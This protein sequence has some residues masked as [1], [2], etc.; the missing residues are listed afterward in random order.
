[1]TDVQGKWALITGASRG[2][3]YHTALFMAGQGA[4]LVL[5]ASKPGNADKVLAEVLAVGV[6]AYTVAADL[7]SQDEISAML[8]EIDSRGTNVQIVLNN[9]GFQVGYRTDYLNTPLSD[10]AASFAVNTIAPAQICY[11]Y[12]P[13]MIEAGFGRIVNT[14]SGIDKD[15]QQAGYS[16]SK[17]ALDK[18]TRD[19]GT[20]VQG[21]DV[22][23]NLADPGWCR[24]DLGGPN[25]F[26]PPESVIPG[27]VTG[28]FANDGKSGRWLGAQD[29]SGMTL[30][31]AVAKAEAIPSPY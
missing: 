31:D 17:A 21:T 30:A 6:Q 7:A 15:P 25:A 22:L 12:L 3:G 11:H 9:A 10:F 8:A 23:I 2:V 20:K 28:V 5:H 4:N 16:A 1:M 19:L 26:H 13:R 14:S 24:T 29:F 18:F 27:I